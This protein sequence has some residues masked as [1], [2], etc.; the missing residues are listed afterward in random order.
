MPFS[1]SL[2]AVKVWGDA[3]QLYF[4][5]LREALAS[6]D[7][8]EELV[9]SMFKAFRERTIN[10]RESW[11]PLCDWLQEN[12]FPNRPFEGEGN[13]LRI[14]RQMKEFLSQRLIEAEQELQGRHGADEQWPQSHE[15]ILHFDKIEP[16]YRYNE[17][18]PPFRPVRC[19]PFVAAQL[20][21]Q[22]IQPSPLLVYELRLIR[23]FDSKWFFEVYGIALALGLAAMPREKN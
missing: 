20:S 3:A 1:W 23:A 14:A 22:G 6:V 4:S 5:S 19:A 11:K 12:L 9:W 8:A 7:S 2:I 16:Q 18:S 21:L 15:V 13:T 10:R 17:K